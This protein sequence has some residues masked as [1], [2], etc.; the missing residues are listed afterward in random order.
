MYSSIIKEI[1]LARDPSF[2]PV[3]QYNQ[4]VD[5]WYSKLTSTM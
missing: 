1:Y 2:P 4:Y 3:E 5:L